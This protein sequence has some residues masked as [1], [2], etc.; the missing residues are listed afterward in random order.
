MT[1]YSYDDADAAERE[2]EKASIRQRYREI[3]DEVAVLE[4]RFQELQE[5]VEMLRA[6]ASGFHMILD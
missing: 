1:V 6:E 4:L 3:K 5:E 2:R